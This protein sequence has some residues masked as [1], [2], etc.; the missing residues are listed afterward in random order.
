M[1]SLYLEQ[2]FKFKPQEG[3][4]GFVEKTTLIILDND[5]CNINFIS[6]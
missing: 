2:Y 6:S 5:N 1:T 3:K 4:T